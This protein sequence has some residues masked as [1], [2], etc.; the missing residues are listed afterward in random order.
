MK[1]IGLFALKLRKSFVLTSA[2]LLF[3]GTLSPTWAVNLA[4]GAGD[5]AVS[6]GV[7][8]YGSFGYQTY[9]VGTGDAL[10]DPVGLLG[11]S[12]TAWESAV[13]VRLAAD[14]SFLTTGKIGASTGQG[15]LPDCGFSSTAAAS[16]ISSFNYGGLS[17]VLVQNI[18]DIFTNGTRT[19]SKLV[20]KYSI[21]N[22]SAVPV[23]FD[24]LRYFEGDLYLGGAGVPDGGGHM[25][26]GSTEYVFLTDIAGSPIT[27]TNFVG[28][29]AE[30]GIV[31]ASGRYEVNQYP[32]FPRRIQDGLPLGNVVY[33]DGTDDDEFVDAGLDYDVGIALSNSIGLDAGASIDYV[34][35]TVWGT[36]EPANLDGGTKSQ[37]TCNQGVGNGSEG[38]DPGTPSLL[39][40]PFGSND[41]NGGAP[42]SPGRAGGAK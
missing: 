28:I 16:A 37:S 38:C 39:H 26:V 12:S 3:A 7:D 5:G 41:E 23:A 34:T 36:G 14:R 10:F 42:G 4:T 27:S 21:T 29:T 31:P 20:Q 15:G 2:A 6:V 32:A 35:T 33:G 24:L 9:G 18:V 22:P 17:F 13:Q 8:C 25:F 30:G 11:P 1:N 40:N 19:G